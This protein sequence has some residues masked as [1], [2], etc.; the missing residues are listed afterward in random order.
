[1]NYIKERKRMIISN[2]WFVLGAAF[3]LGA[4]YWQIRECLMPREIRDMIAYKPQ[5]VL[6]LASALVI[7][8][9]CNVRRGS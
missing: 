1:M 8:M 3:L 7:R 5:D 6:V 2:I 9:G 4:M